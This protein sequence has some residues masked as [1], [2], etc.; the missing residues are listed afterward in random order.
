MERPWRDIR[1]NMEE[2]LLPLAWQVDEK[3]NEFKDKVEMKAK[4]DGFW[5][6]LMWDAL[7]TLVHINSPGSGLK[8]QRGKGIAGQKWLGGLHAIAIVKNI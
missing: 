6:Q 8:F 1:K 3:I 7:L 4:E 5:T 2:T